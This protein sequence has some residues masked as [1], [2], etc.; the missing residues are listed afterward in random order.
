M[1]KSDWIDCEERLPEERKEGDCTISDLVEV[2]LSDGSYDKDF[3]INGRWVI[4]CKNS[5]RVYPIKWK[6]RKNEI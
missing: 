4:Y 6:E 2:I 1:S 5:C 3:R